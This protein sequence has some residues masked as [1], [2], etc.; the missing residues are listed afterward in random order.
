M[1]KRDRRNGVHG[2]ARGA[3]NERRALMATRRVLERAGWVADARLATRE[4]DEAGID[5][6]VEDDAGRRCIQVKSS[7]RGA[8]GRSRYESRGIAVVVVTPEKWDQQLEAE[9]ADAI[10]AR[11]TR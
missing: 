4:E 10:G 5:I 9:I 8:K 6:V 11:C 3:E 7:K 2:H 1:A